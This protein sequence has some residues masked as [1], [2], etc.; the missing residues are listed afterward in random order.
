M[1][2]RRGGGVGRDAVGAAVEEGAA[3]GHVLDGEGGVGEDADEILADLF[4][5]VAGE[6]AA[7]DVGLG[8]LGRALGAWPAEIMVATQVVRRMEL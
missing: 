1:S 5:G 4:L 2:L 3:V 8:G 7:V 6:D